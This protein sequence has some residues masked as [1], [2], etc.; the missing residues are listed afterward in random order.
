MASKAM[1]SMP[2]PLGIPCRPDAS[3][4]WDSLLKSSKAAAPV[5]AL[6]AAVGRSTADSAG[7]SVAAAA[8]AATT[9]ST[10]TERHD[11][12]WGHGEEGQRQ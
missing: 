10:A 11:A 9:S 4:I 1:E 3:K 2:R 12:I 7:P 5:A 8:A 6:A